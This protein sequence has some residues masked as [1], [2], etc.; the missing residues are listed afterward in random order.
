MKNAVRAGGVWSRRAGLT[1]LTSIAAAL[2]LAFATPAAV[3]VTNPH[4]AV[5]DSAGTVGDCVKGS[6]RGCRLDVGASVYRMSGPQ[7]IPSG[8]TTQVLFD[9]ALYDTDAM[10]DAA[11]ST[12]VVNTPGRYLLNAN[13]F[14]AGL[15]PLESAIHDVVILVNGGAVAFNSQIVDVTQATQAVS[16]VLDLEEGDEIALTMFQNTGNDASSVALTGIERPVSPVLQAELL[17]AAD[18][19][20]SDG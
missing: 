16:V 1:A 17:S 13:V 5:A 10:F 14:W 2:S 20:K 7:T 12:L 3:G 8:V 11:D 18:S 4:V 6:K 15:T 9:T 19:K